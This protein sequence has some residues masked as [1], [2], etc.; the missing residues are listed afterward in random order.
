MGHQTG[1]LNGVIGAFGLVSAVDGTPNSE[2]RHT[3]FPQW[4]TSQS[5]VILSGVSPQ[6]PDVIEP[7]V[8]RIFRELAVDF[9]E[10]EIIGWWQDEGVPPSHQP[11]DESGV[12]RGTFR[13]YEDSIDWTDQQSAKRAVTVFEIVWGRSEPS[14]RDFYAADLRRAGWEFDDTGHLRNLNRTYAVPDSLTS[15]T[16]PSAILD[17]FARIEATIEE[18]PRDAIGHA[19]ELIESTAK[20]VLLERDVPFEKNDVL[21]SLINR[22]Q[23]AVG[24]RAVAA[25]SGP[26]S[27]T[28]VKRALGGLASAAIA[29]NE[30]RNLGYGAGH[31]GASRP[32]GLGPRHAH[33][34]VGAARTWCQMLLDTLADPDAPWHN[35]GPDASGSLEP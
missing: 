29:V 5:V 11:N 12:R 10:R 32:V 33:L 14:R 31:G 2:R 13:N 7:R 15:L 16:D 1:A 35:A 8:R 18:A 19:K 20:V 27:T 25:G 4:L 23:E 30:L 28:A 17:A 3:G 24:L 26:D 6:L 21:P 22:A 9:V 34:A